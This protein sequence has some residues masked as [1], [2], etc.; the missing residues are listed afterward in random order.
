MTWK[1]V[2]TAV[3]LIPLAVSLVLWGST[4]MVSIA[5]A[6][7]ILLALFEYFALGEAIGHRAYRFWTATCALVLIY[8]QWR[9]RAEHGYAIGLVALERRLGG[10]P[11][12]LD[13]AFF[14]FVLGIA[15][16]TLFT[17]RPMVEGLPSAGISASGLIL[18]AFPLSFA[19]PLHG[20]GAQGPALLLFAMVIIWVSD[21]AAYFVGRSIGKNALAPKLSPNKT[22]EGTV[23]GFLGSLV[24]ALAFAPW[25][26]VPLVHLLAMAAVGNVA[27]QVGDLLES[28]YKRSAGVK[29]SG[30]L[31]P[32]HGGVL[33]RIDALILA[34]PVVWYY[35]ILIYSPRS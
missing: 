7:V 4:A 8:S 22:W 26:N 27:G 15:T 12:S 21:T 11:P 35:W 14:L 13:A 28:A 20:A 23:A 34:I 17:K 24:V 32:G 18:I 29:D 31:L 3:V 9:G 2:A 19:I 25:V 6:L 16:L 33:D 10:G 5:V 1:R 30:S